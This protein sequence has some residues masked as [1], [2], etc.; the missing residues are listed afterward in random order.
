MSESESSSHSDLTE[1]ANT[2][3][4]REIQN[5]NGNGHSNYGTND[6]EN[7]EFEHSSHQVS[8]IGKHKNF[9]SEIDA[10]KHSKTAESLLFC[11]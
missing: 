9:L 3:K 1:D 6:N 7:E 4:L 2:L 8:L 11:S 5:G 10:I